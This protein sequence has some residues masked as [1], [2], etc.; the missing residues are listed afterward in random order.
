MK[1]HPQHLTLATLLMVT[2]MARAQATPDSSGKFGDDPDARPTDEI[3]GRYPFEAGRW[4]GG[5][6]LRSCKTQSIHGLPAKPKDESH[7]ARRM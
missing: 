4:E 2:T 5:E 3:G 7:A 1:R 6:G